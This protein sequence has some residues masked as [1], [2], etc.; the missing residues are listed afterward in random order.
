VRQRQRERPLHSP[1]IAGERFCGKEED[2]EEA[3]VRPGHITK[4]EETLLPHILPGQ[5]PH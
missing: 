4:V 1:V 2:E 3:A 5:K